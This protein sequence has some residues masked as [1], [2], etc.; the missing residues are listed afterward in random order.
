MSQFIPSPNTFS[1]LRGKVVVLT[2]G[3]SGIGLA[4]TTLLHRVGA[5][6][7]FGDV[8]RDAGEALVASLAKS[9]TDEETGD[10]ATGT[11][12]GTGMSTVMFVPCDVKEI[13]RHIRA[14]PGRAGSTRTRR[15]CGFVCGD[16]GA[17]LVL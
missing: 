13:R 17:R 16:R 3:S 11:S 6:V 14:V 15:P 10:V 4:L 8:S 5:R 9:S 1:R 12:I 2:G 7:A